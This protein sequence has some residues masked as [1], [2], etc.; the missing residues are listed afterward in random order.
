MRL[1]DFLEVVKKAILIK[2]KDGIDKQ[3]IN[4]VIIVA[5]DQLDDQ[6]KVDLIFNSL[7]DKDIDDII[8][9][10]KT[11]DTAKELESLNQAELIKYRTWVFKTLI[12]FACIIATLI[13]VLLFFM[14]DNC[15]P[16]ATTSY[17]T[18][19]KKII[20]IVIFNKTD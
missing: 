17:L 10:E 19:I 12:I 18:E 13:S 8:A 15:D 6:T 5:F 9:K 1:P 4:S 2:A 11:A 7:D 16:A 20:D 3:N 14:N